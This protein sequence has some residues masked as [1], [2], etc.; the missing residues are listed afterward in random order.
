[1][2]LPFLIAI[3]VYLTLHTHSYTD[4]LEYSIIGLSDPVGDVL[5]MRRLSDFSLLLPDNLFQIDFRS[6]SNVRIAE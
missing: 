5:G 3:R 6:S 1:M 2:F 4:G